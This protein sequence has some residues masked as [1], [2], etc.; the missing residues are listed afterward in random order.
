MPQLPLVVQPVIVGGV[1]S[2]PPPSSW[3]SPGPLKGPW[4]VCLCFLMLLFSFFS[5]LFFFPSLLLIS[6]GRHR[7]RCGRGRALIAA[8][9]FDS[10]HGCRGCGHVRG[11]GRVITVVTAAIFIRPN[12]Q[13][14]FSF[15]PMKRE[16]ASINRGGGRRKMVGLSVM[17]KFVE[18]KSG[19]GDFSFLFFLFCTNLT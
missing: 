15:Q 19:N 5:L 7:C 13:A 17:F 11:R 14:L 1:F 2:R 18:T 16:D 4:Y 10:A 3:T 6:H 12:S 9:L 8:I